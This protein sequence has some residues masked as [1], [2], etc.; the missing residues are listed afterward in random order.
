MN[1]H[2]VLERAEQW[3]KEKDETMLKICTDMLARGSELLSESELLIVDTYRKKLI[4]KKFAFT[5]PCPRCGAKADIYEKEI[6]H[7]QSENTF[8]IFKKW[9]ADCSECDVVFT[10]IANSKQEAI[11]I[12]NTRK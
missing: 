7:P 5:K 8:A 10:E 9:T 6:C 2:W 3:Q 1:K 4:D 12:W 11:D